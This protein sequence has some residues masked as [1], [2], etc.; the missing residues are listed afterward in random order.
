MEACFSVSG[1]LLL[2]LLLLLLWCVQGPSTHV[3][4]IM[5]CAGALHW[6]TNPYVHE[7]KFDAASQMVEVRTSTLFGRSK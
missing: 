4:I 1:L 7:L 6:I 2:L 3:L 5:V